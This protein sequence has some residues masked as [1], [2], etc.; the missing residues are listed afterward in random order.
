MVIPQGVRLHNN[1]GDLE[2]PPEDSQE[3]T[4]AD[5]MRRFWELTDEL[6]TAVI[7]FL[8]V[9]G[10]KVSADLWE[11]HHKISEAQHA[12]N[13]AVGDLNARMRRGDCDWKRSRENRSTPPVRSLPEDKPDLEPPLM[14]PFYSPFNFR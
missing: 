10:D 13:Q 6:A 11:H 8:E 9:V 1:I 12:A 7:A 4:P 14:H 5:C 3:T 2:Q